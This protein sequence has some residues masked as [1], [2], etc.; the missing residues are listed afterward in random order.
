MP[1][2][3][4]MRILRAV[5]ACALEYPDAPLDAVCVGAHLAAVAA[6]SRVGLASRS[7][8][9][10]RPALE[11]PSGLPATAHG[12][13]RLLAADPQP[14]ALARS[15]ALAAVNALLP[16][17]AEA[18][19]AKGQDLLLRWGR[20]RRVAVVGH[21]P[22]VARLA[23]AFAALD[24]LELDPRPGDLPARAA[25]EVLPRADLAA[26]TAATLLNNTLA[27]LLGLCRPGAV[28]MLLG[29]STPLAPCLFEHGVTVLAGSQAT[30]PGAVLDGVAAGLP[31]KALPGV[32]RL[33]WERGG[34]HLAGR[35]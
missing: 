25:A 18:V 22:F 5:A 33:A 9:H 11:P 17:P 13:A 29:P 12:L 1:L 4:Q 32:R 6:G 31:F 3:D 14:F 27:G 21:F 35:P 20:G 23:G 24:V 16:L 19:P 26:I 10:G 28:V 15:L 34:A 7:D 30:D 2:P 8:A